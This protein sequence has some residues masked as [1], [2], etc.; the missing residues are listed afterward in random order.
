MLLS[1]LQLHFSFQGML[2]LI[3]FQL[4]KM[5]FS[6]TQLLPQGCL[7]YLT[8]ASQIGVKDNHCINSTIHQHGWYITKI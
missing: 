5:N 2:E 4:T 3:S 8:S 1:N 6:G 7:S